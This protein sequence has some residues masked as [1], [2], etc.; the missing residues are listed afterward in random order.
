MQLVIR[1][2]RGRR[3][4]ITSQPTNDPATTSAPPPA[5]MGHSEPRVPDPVPAVELATRAAGTAGS[6]ALTP[7]G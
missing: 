1:L 2:P 6:A 7:P 4:R 5:T 3:A